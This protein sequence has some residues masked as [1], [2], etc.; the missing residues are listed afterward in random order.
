MTRALI[1]NHMRRAQRV[2]TVWTD[3]RENVSPAIDDSMWFKFLREFRDPQKDPIVSA[4]QRMYE[5]EISK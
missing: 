3:V 2:T 5:K 4:C 1:H